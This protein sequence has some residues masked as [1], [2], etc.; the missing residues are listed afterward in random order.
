MFLRIFFSLLLFFSLEKTFAQEALIKGLISGHQGERLSNVHITWVE[1]GL[2][3]SSNE[4]GHYSIKIQ[5]GLV[6]L[7]FR[8]EFYKEKLISLQIKPKEKHTLDIILEPE[9]KTLN[10]VVVEGEK[11]EDANSRMQA[12][13]IKIDPKI[14][15][16]LPSAFGDFNKILA[17]V[18]LGVM[19]NSELSSQY[20]VRGGNFDENL[21]YVNDMEVYR[22]FLVRSGQQEGLSFVNPDMVS[23][24]EFSA[25]G[26]QA[27]YG[28]KLSS[29]L[30]VKYK[31]PKK[32]KGSATAGLL[33]YAAHIENATK[34]RRISYIVGARNKNSQ[35]LLNTLPVK[36]QYKPHFYDLQAMVVFDLTKRKDSLDFEKRTTLS[37]L[38]SV[39]INRY[40]IFPTESQTTFGTLANAMKLDLNFSGKET[41]QYNTYQN[42]LKFSHKVNN[43]L[44]LDLLGSYVHS[45]EREYSDIE[46]IYSLCE[47]QTSQ[48]AANFNQCILTTGSGAN[49]EHIRNR[50]QATVITLS[51]KGQFDWNK[52]NQV[53][54][55]IT[56]GN[57]I[58][59]DQLSDYTFSDS[60]QYVT[61]T[62]TI[63]NPGI[64][65]NTL[66]TQAYIQNTWRP[67]SFQ[68]ITY[69]VRFG[70]WTLNHQFIASPRIQYAVKPRGWKRDVIFKAS[71]GVY[72]QPAFYREMLMYNGT[73][74]KNIKAQTSYHFI[75]GMDYNFKV[76]DRKFK[77]ISEVYYKYLTHVVPYD[78]NNVMLRYYGVN[79]AVAFAEGADFRISGE[80]IK[81]EQS[82]F[83]LSFLNT[84]ENVSGPL[85]DGRGWIRRPTDQNI[86]AGI[87]FQDH[88]PNNPSIKVF[89]NLVYG[90]GLPFGPPNTPAFRSAFSGPSYNRVDIGFSKLIS[91]QDK[92]KLT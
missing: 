27:K 43:R 2:S 39:A 77:F 12:S 44:R 64:S 88:I 9:I 81:G 35:Y 54:W 24:V 51:H 19:S 38:T 56:E 42:G 78:M 41:M 14:P 7:R 76:I 37:V 69:G 45:V 15:K 30:A 49:Y 18:G 8:L 72:Q 57:E 40:N 83:S 70:Y 68:V 85:G 31:E 71:A 34:N 29:V 84:K 52:K 20:G 61:V 89:L 87:F 55:G 46:T 36:G 66:R 28:D 62:D 59:K 92:E 82:W 65:L 67:D 16:Y 80:F 73:L 4:K 75:I 90:S 1:G 10:A 11:N 53:L 13:S 79:N 63:N 5:P 60:A 91:F 74:N 25:G 6:T 48:N 32:F 58:I 26:W 50:L 47:V 3:A 86:T 23:D 21:V 33:G 17:T 22:P